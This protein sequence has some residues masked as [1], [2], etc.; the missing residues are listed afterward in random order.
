MATVLRE[1][2]PARGAGERQILRRIVRWTDIVVRGAD[3]LAAAL[4]CA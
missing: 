1:R 2:S 4:P 3:A